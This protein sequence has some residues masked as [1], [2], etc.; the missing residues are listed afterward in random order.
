M[1]LVQYQDLEASIIILNHY[2]VSDALKNLQKN[3]NKNLYTKI[4]V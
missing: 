3:M 4:F 1:Y 2:L